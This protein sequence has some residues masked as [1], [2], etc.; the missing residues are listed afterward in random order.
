VTF[1]QNHD[2][3]PD[4]DWKFR[5]NHE[6]YKAAAVCNLL[7]SI[8]GIP[9]LYYG[10]EIEFMKGATQDID[11]ND[12]KVS[13]TGRAYFGDHLTAASLA[14]TQAHPLYQHL[15]RLNQIRLAVPALQRGQMSTVNGGGNNLSFTRDDNGESFVAVGLTIGSGQHFDLGVP[16][17]TYVDAVTGRSVT[18]TGG[19]LSFD[20]LD[21]SAGIY[22]KDG[23]GK[24]GVDGVYLR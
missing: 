8:R 10:E 18:V 17:G 4:N 9:C 16:N 11:G 15:K 14:E 7:W 3:G 21:N 19:T 5:F 2:I 6:Q 23:P 12:M 13:D 24:I 1:F 20:V 22:V